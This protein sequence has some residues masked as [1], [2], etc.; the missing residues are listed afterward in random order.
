MPSNPLSL[1]ENLLP[2][3]AAQ[4]ARLSE[5]EG[6]ADEQLLI[7][8]R[9][10]PILTT[11]LADSRPPWAAGLQVDRVIGPIADQF[12]RDT[13]FDI[14]RRV[15]QVRFVR[16]AG[17][18]PF[19]A[20]PLFQL[21][22]GGLGS[23][24]S[25]VNLGAGSFWIATNLLA[26][27]ADAGVYT[28]LRIAG[29][30]IQFDSPVSIAGDEV[31]VPAGI[32]CRVTLELNPPPQ[33]AGTGPGRDVRESAFQPPRN[34]AIVVAASSATLT[35][36]DSASLRVYGQSVS[37]NP[38]SA[39]AT[40]LP[41]FNRVKIPL[42]PMPS[43]FTVGVVQSNSLRPDGTAPITGGGWALP[44]A[45]IAPAD[46]GEASGVGALMLELGE[47]LSATWT[48]QTEPVPLGPTILFLDE[49]RLAT[50]SATAHAYDVAQHPALPG[51]M[52][53]GRIALLWNHTFP[54]TYFADA[55]GSEAVYTFARFRTSLE[56]PVD[57][58][59]D[60]VSIDAIAGVIF[61]ENDQGKFLWLAGTITMPE[62][63]RGL[64]FSLTNAVLHAS[65][66]LSFNMLARYDGT[67]ASEGV[68]ALGYLLA[69][70]YPSLPDPY[71]TNASSSRERGFG[72]LYSFA[73]WTPT[74][75]GVQ[76][77]IPPT[78]AL[79]LGERRI[80]GGRMDTVGLSETPPTPA[81][82]PGGSGC[83]GLG[84]FGSRVA[85]ST[86]FDPA[87][88]HGPARRRLADALA[89]EAVPRLILLDL[90][91]NISQLGVA[92]RLP[93]EQRDSF[94]TDPPKPLTVRGLDL[95]IDG[96]MLT[97]LTLPAVQWEPVRSLP[98]PDDPAFPPQLRFANSGVPSLVDVPS[99]NLVPVTPEAALG[100]II[101][102]FK[103]PN[104]RPSR[105]RFTLP[106]G[107]IGSAVLQRPGPGGGALVS[108]TRPTSPDGLVGEHQLRI[109]A[110]DPS[111][112]AGQTPALPGFAVQ[113]PNAIPS[114]GSP[115]PRSILGT[116]VSNIF[117]GYLGN[118]GTRPLVPV[119]RI[120]L[121]GYGESLFSGWINPTDDET[122][123]SKADFKVMIG[124]TAH[125]VVQVRSILCPYH[126]PVVRTV[127]I[128]RRNNAAIT[129]H[130]S[131]WIPAGDGAYQF[132]AGSGIVTHPG[133]VQRIINVSHI[134]ETGERIT[135]AGIE[136]AAVYYQGDLVLDGSARPVPVKQHFGW[137][138]IGTTPLTAAAYAALL[139]D[140]SPL[141]GPLDTTI[142]IGG[143]RQ[144][145]RLH[146]VGVG[147]TQI[148]GGPQF[149]MGAWG[150][151]MFP[152]GG[153]DWSILQ[154]ADTS[155]APQPVPQDEGLPLIRANG[156][157]TPYR[158]AQPSDLGRESTPVRDY[159]ILHSTGTQ[160][161]FF[162]RPKIEPGNLSRIS[163]TERPVIADPYVMATA[164]GPF[165]RQADAIPFPAA[166]WALAIDNTGNYKLETSSP[167]FPAGIGRRTMKQ[168]GSVKSDLDYGTSV[169][170][171]QVDTAQPI[172][173]RFALTNA[174]SIMN[175][176]AMGD[177]IT[178]N[179]DIA[180]Q[181]GVETVFNNP[182]LALGGALDIV[183]DLLTIL[184]D[185]GITGTMR[186]VMTNEWSIEVTVTVP[187]VDPMG[188]DLQIPP[189]VPNPTVKFSDTGVSVG[190][191]VWPDASSA[192][193]EIEGTPMFAVQSIPGLYVI[194][195]I[196]FEIEMSTE[197]GV[198]YKLLIGFGVA[199]SLEAGPFELEGLIAITF[200]AIWGD[201][202]VGYGIG[203]LV[204]V[205]AE[206]A[207]IVAVE[208]TLEG[209][210]ARIMLAQGTP[211]ETV[212]GVAKL[213][214]AIEVS[215]FLVLSISFEFE[216]T[217]VNRVRGSLPESAIPAIV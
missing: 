12:G 215:I 195:I 197:T 181:A 107:M 17:G 23:T 190:I 148:S 24:T 204:K 146:R 111:L 104:P 75:A 122:Q 81:T 80:P 64:A 9:S 213:T 78:Q 116:S 168:A 144:A 102:N 117:N 66:P 31:I 209:R 153:G 33:P 39:P 57:V 198:H 200:F 97:L 59:G 212:F 121:S 142:Q 124:R 158:F 214:F 192:S 101:D 98:V 68:L 46:L 211:D 69:R 65:L 35:V 202:A 15:R 138:K 125:E 180:A 40:Y 132:R 183:Q 182:K 95:A 79:S 36:N 45:R 108:E 120:D 2:R 103:G 93:I 56:Q 100:T 94:R 44:A 16:T 156:A 32:G 207:P 114:D 129:R 112:P 172:P 72:Q 152:P 137:V 161:A 208:L 83:L 60:R 186:T 139:A 140:T 8:R 47:G 171:Y 51:V 130:D 49:A 128:E 174:K 145:M 169:V 87:S 184:E 38:F 109:D 154:A 187:F 25:T 188:E 165:P 96:R 71:A 54:V 30:R 134:R 27:P 191:E 141:C 177:M 1:L 41:I 76:F 210:L 5:V 89:F 201:T 203:F 155:G 151:L 85:Q 50:A 164:L 43:Q 160:R 131:G 42:Q 67:T 189:L 10:L 115:G 123:V 52:G 86:V 105:A 14:F 53:R 92:L 170:T 150:G 199:Y 113:L 110:R 62:G 91:T 166:P 88:E 74:N 179:A 135:R 4:Q 37:F 149:V 127:T 82:T 185:L 13:F 119:T 7:H 147:V 173:W 18:A 28:G 205:S 162:R 26:S 77:F 157:G 73:G 118:G 216:A 133:V 11:Q 19:L 193:F 20:V 178:L 106:F 196:S 217:Q 34:V 126:V 99:V 21:S 143:G 90:S 163:S 167:T 206:I 176:T 29:G 159:G 6:I 58:N 63:S 136:Y 3:D 175:S 22:I 194:A 70:I 84:L 55:R 61:I 48:G